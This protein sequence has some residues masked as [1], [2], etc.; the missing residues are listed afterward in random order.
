MFDYN[1]QEGKKIKKERKEMGGER[2]VS[3]IHA[4]N[5]ED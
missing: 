3:F 2:R 1:P 5:P 4:L